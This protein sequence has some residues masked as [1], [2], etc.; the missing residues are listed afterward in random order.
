MTSLLKMG[1]TCAKA[2]YMKARSRKKTF[3][4]A[5]ENQLPYGSPI[6]TPRNLQGGYVQQEHSLKSIGQSDPLLN[7]AFNNNDV[8]SLNNCNHVASFP[9]QNSDSKSSPL[10]KD[11]HPEAEEHSQPTMSS[12]KMWFL[13][14]GTTFKRKLGQGSYAT[15]VLAD[16]KSAKGL[17]AVKVIDLIG[18]KRRHGAS[19]RVAIEREVEIMCLLR[20]EHLIQ[21]LQRPVKLYGRYLC[22]MMELANQD[23]LEYIQ[24]QGKFTNCEGRR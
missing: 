17:V 2:P 10:Y 20:H 15:V 24:K 5:Q 1:I 12:V 22:L 21:V 7:G 19:T 23:L 11:C 14:R 16:N 4:I 8:N 13:K 9:S 18:Q 6:V 3:A